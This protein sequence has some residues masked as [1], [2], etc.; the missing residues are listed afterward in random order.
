MLFTAC[1]AVAGPSLDIRNGP[2][3]NNGWTGPPN[4]PTAGQGQWFLDPNTG[5]KEFLTHEFYDNPIGYGGGSQ[6]H[7]AI[8][9]IVTYLDL[10][11]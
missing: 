10:C 1:F 8:S 2:V 6:G 4:D 5:A 7:F 11:G 3:F 9:G